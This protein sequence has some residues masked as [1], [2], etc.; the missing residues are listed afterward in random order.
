M[1]NWIRSGAPWIWL[2]GG[3]VS[4]SLLS[5]LGLLLLIGWKGL[6][7]FWPA[8]L[9]QW[10]VTALTPVQ[11]E[12]LQ[13]SSKL[14]GQV[15]ARSFVPKSYLPEGTVKQLDDDEDFATRLS[16]KIANRELYPAD[17]ISV[18]QIQLDE[19][20]TPEELAVIERSSGGYFLAKCLLSRMGTSFTTV[21]F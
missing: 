11:G 2:T 8:P 20:T 5:V 19:P 12:V 14:I 17:F 7:F 1:L 10:N 16:I 9:Y 3:A 13:E 4:I 18:L 21:T 15:Y 6:T